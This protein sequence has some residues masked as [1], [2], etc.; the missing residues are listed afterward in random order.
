MPAFQIDSHFSG[1]KLDKLSENEWLNLTRGLHPE[2]RSTM[3]VLFA[4]L[5]YK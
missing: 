5:L 3:A 2:R 1:N 4:G